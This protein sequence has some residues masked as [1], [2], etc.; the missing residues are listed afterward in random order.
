MKAKPTSKLPKRAARTGE[1]RSQQRMVGRRE[2][3][4]RADSTKEPE[5]SG[6][7]GVYWRAAQRLADYYQKAREERF[8][9]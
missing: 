1:A 3:E 8:P 6:A 9:I 2:L 7:G 4:P 5:R